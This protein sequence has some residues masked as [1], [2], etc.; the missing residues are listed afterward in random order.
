MSGGT[1]HHSNGAIRQGVAGQSF[2]A[3]ITALASLTGVAPDNLPSAA[4]AGRR[5]EPS[6]GKWAGF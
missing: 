6:T 4:I 5:W 2:G 1:V 3:S